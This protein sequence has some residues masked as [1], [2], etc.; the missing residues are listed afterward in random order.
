MKLSFAVFPQ[1]TIFIKPTECSF[2]YPA[3]RYNFKF[4]SVFTVV[5]K[6]FH[7]YS[8]RKKNSTSLKKGDAVKQ[9]NS[10]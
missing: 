7:V 2:Y 8:Y 4:S 6:G 10:Y 5:F 3:F 9:V 1:P